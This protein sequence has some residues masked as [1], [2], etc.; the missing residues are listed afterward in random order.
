MWI[1]EIITQKCFPN[2]LELA[3]VTP[4]FKKENASLLK[5]YR[6]VDVLPVVSENYE[7]IMQNQ[8]LEYIEKIY[9]PTY[10]DTEKSAV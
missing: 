8:I 9:P 1:K 2:N 5:D 3:Y 4:V 7:R 6:P 10:V